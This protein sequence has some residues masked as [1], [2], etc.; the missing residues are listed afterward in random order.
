MED[1]I[2]LTTRLNGYPKRYY[3]Y[4]VLQIETPQHKEIECLFHVQILQSSVRV[5]AVHPSAFKA[6]HLG[7]L[8]LSYII[9]YKDQL[10]TPFRC[11]LCICLFPQ[12]DHEFLMGLIF[13]I[14]ICLCHLKLNFSIENIQHIKQNRHFKDFRK[15]PW[16]FQTS[17]FGN[18]REYEKKLRF[19]VH[20]KHGKFSHKVNY[21]ASP[22]ETHFLIQPVM[23]KFLVYS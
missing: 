2:S 9:S 18:G 21:V 8:R 13:H 20:F 12:V 1:I 7:N 4:V 22:F 14:Y 17:M 23:Q 5:C 16:C 19:I 3:T 10:P 15:H 11:S 6:F